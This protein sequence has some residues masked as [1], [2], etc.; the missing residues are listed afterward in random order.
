MWLLATFAVAILA[1][2]PAAS[3]FHHAAFD[4]SYAIL[5]PDRLLP[6]A[7]GMMQTTWSLSGIISPALAASIIAL[8]AVL[9]R[10]VAFLA[11]IAAMRD[12]TP[13]VLVID[14]ATFWR[15][16]VNRCHPREC[17]SFGWPR[18]AREHRSGGNRVCEEFARKM[19]P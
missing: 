2:A 10:D 7:N 19:E 3:A 17:P 4:A 14:A 16:P 12:G 8:P 11:P 6:R 18:H 5:V 13:L 9:P 1:S 15:R